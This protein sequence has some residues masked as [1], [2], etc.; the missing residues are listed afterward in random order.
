MCF[1]DQTLLTWLMNVAF[2]CVSLAGL[3]LAVLLGRPRIWI[4]QLSVNSNLH[5][6]VIFSVPPDNVAPKSP[7]PVLGWCGSLV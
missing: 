2:Q 7:M 1:P 3:P 4:H 6:T 5:L